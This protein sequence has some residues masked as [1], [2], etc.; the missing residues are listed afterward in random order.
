MIC[1]TSVTFRRMKPEEILRVA[2]RAGIEGIEWGGDV[3]VPAGDLAAAR[4]VRALCEDA[5]IPALSLGSY[6]F[7][8]A[9]MDFRPVLETALALGVRDVRIWAGAVRLDGSFYQPQEIAQGA[10]ELRA[11]CDCAQAEGVRIHVERHR[12]TMTHTPA[13]ASSL[14][15]QAQAPNLHSYWQ[16]NPE[17]DTEENLSCIAALR[18]HISHVHV[19]TWTADNTRLALADGADAWKRYIAALGPRRYMIEFVRGEE[20]AQLLQDASHLRAWLASFA[21]EA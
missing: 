14:F 12:G 11:V 8:N 7:L 9:G 21:Q 5:G 15:A 13:Q 17:K 10:Q 1:L 3:H 16:P 2:A 19:F 20:P 6:F 4:R 18:P